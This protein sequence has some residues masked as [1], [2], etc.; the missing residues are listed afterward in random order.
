MLL[1]DVSLRQEISVK[2]LEQL[3]T[4]LRVAGLVK[5]TRGPHGGYHLTRPPGEIN[6]YEIIKTLEG[7]VSLTDCVSDHESC[8]RST[9][10]A[11]H[12]IWAAINTTVIEQLRA[13]TLREMAE[14]QRELEDAHSGMYHI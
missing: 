2:Y 10:C 6:L 14:R 1:R 4:S 13:V 11:S 7:P 12:E 8:G 9:S 5:S 3:V